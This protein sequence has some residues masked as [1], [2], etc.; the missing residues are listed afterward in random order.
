MFVYITCS[1]V[2]SATSPPAGVASL[3]LSE[4]GTHS[5][6]SRLEILDDNQFTFLLHRKKER[7][8]LNGF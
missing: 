3:K 7:G 1:G 6:I 8:C 4:T 5:K 2:S